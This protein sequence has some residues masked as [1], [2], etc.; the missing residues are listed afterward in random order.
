MEKK[1]VSKKQQA[2]VRRYKKAHYENISVLVKKGKKEQIQAHAQAM[3]ES[4][5]AFIN[6]AID[7]AMENDPS[8]F[9]EN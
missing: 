4:T 3:G 2:C 8:D 5:N 6:R 9:F 1:K 7:E